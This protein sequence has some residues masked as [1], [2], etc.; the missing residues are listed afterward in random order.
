M[1]PPCPGPLLDDVA[2]FVHEWWV[3]LIH[4]SKHTAQIMKWIDIKACK[5]YNGLIILQRINS[6]PG[7]FRHWKKRVTRNMPL[8]YI[9][10]VLALLE[11]MR[12][13]VS[14]RGCAPHFQLQQRQYTTG[15]AN[16]WSNGLKNDKII[17]RDD[18]WHYRHPYCPIM[19]GR[20]KNVT[21][22]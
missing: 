16:A 13:L 17:M 18:N 19:A 21:N 9:P 2:I 15:R 3:C 20:K 22:I 7:T 12:F 6:L 1:R 14:R 10:L 11:T 8:P 4:G 5:S